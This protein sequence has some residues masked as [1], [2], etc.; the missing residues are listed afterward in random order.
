[1]CKY[2]KLLGMFVLVFLVFCSVSLHAAADKPNFIFILIDD[3]GYGDVGPN[4]NTFTD[5][6]H[7]DQLAA[8]GMRFTDAYAA[9]PNCSPTRASV[10]T[11]KWPAR[12]RLTQYLPGNAG[13]KLLPLLQAPLPDGLDLNEITLAEALK[14]HGYATAS[15]GKWHLGGEGYL[16][17]LQGFDLNYGGSE[18]GSHKSMFS[19]HKTVGLPDG[20]KGEYLS[21]RLTDEALDFIEQNSDQPFFLYMPHYAVHGPIQAKAK[22]IEKYGA[23]RGAKVNKNRAKYAA[24]VESV[25]DSV[26][27]IVQKLKQ[28]KLTENT[29]VFFFSDNGGKESLGASNGPLSHGKGWLYEG[30]VREPLIVT[31]PGTISAGAVERTAVQSIDFYPTILELAGAPEPA[32]HQSDGLSLMPL[33]LQTGK[34]KRD[35]LFWH[36][37]HYSNA[38]SPPTS[39]IRQGDWKL[40]EFFEDSHLELYNLGPDIGEENNLATQH[41]DIV[42]RLHVQ[43]KDWRHSIDAVYPTPNPDYK[44]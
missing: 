35:T 6:P 20:P 31:W 33:L 10:L 43:L 41:P 19:P 32:G 14:P 22:L 4:G 13:R 2:K 11:G 38:G 44:K 42:A 27:R 17:Q 16:P 40:I 5:T 21:D 8:S 7:I 26:G 24:M 18:A 12:L 39:S 30:G 36:Y 23:R 34:L 1:M 15:I 9:A 29:V 3:M 25:D 37:P 28:L